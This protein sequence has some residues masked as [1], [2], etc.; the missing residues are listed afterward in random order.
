MLPR[1]ISALNGVHPVIGI[2]PGVDVSPA[3]RG[4]RLR[5]VQPGDPLRGVHHDK[6]PVA[7][8]AEDGHRPL[9]LVGARPQKYLGLP[10]AQDVLGRGLGQVGVL[11]RFSNAVN[12]DAVLAQYLHKVFQHRGRG[13]DADRLSGESFRGDPNP[14]Q[15]RQ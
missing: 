8:V 2:S 7:G 15:H 9:L 12:L 5:G 4:G 13:D 1:M 14:C 11:V 10:D 3:R 6:T